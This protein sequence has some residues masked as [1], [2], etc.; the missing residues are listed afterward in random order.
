LLLL[1]LLTDGPSTQAEVRATSAWTLVCHVRLVADSRLAAIVEALLAMAR[2]D[3]AK[4]CQAA[5]ALVDLL[6]MTP[7]LLD[8]EAQATIVRG[9][10]AI[11][12][13]PPVLTPHT[14]NR[15][16]ATAHTA[17]TALTQGRGGCVVCDP[18]SPKASQS[19]LDVFLAWVR[20]GAASEQSRAELVPALM[21]RLLAQPIPLK[22]QT[23]IFHI[24]ASLAEQG[25]RCAVCARCVRCVRLRVCG[26]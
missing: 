15:T 20:N 24:F 4:S 13:N 17:H 5:S 10:F 1:N 12:D 8:E 6:T 26:S 9:A 14:L 11:W 2:R 23:G 3:D 19:V 18:Q 25:T 16:R 7:P 21:G 22:L